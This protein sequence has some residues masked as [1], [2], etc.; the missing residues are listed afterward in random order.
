MKKGKKG[1][2]RTEWALFDETNKRWPK[3]IFEDSGDEI[4]N[5]RFLPL[6]FN[7][8][9]LA[10]QRFDEEPGRTKNMPPWFRP[11]S[12]NPTFLKFV[13]WTYFRY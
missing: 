5:P 6:H 11:I 2:K 1:K 10:P 4:G 8:R 12:P 3:S 7:A 13:L 9:F